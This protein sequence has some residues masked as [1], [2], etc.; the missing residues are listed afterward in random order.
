MNINNDLK[1]LKKKRVAWCFPDSWPPVWHV[2]SSRSNTESTYRVPA[3]IE[4]Q[5]WSAETV[6]GIFF[7]WLIES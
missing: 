7:F 4:K 2:P 6:Y 5:P 3:R 1:L